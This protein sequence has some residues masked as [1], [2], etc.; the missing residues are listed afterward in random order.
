MDFG[1]RQKLFRVEGCWA[2]VLEHIS[3]KKAWAGWVVP[4][5][6]QKDVFKMFGDKGR[7]T[8]TGR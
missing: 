7:G 3:R 4:M 2:R 1:R 8:V 5:G 6:K